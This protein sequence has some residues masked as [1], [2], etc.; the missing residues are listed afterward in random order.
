MR[1]GFLELVT[2]LAILAYLVGPKQ[3]PR[4][5]NVIIESKKKFKEE[6]MKE[7]SGD[8]NEEEKE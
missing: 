8:T 7:K 5:T 4:L 2:I 1:L 3:I 6:M